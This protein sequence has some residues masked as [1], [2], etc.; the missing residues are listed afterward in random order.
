[1]QSKPSQMTAMDVISIVQLLNQNG[2]HV[3]I[4]GGWG[5]DAFWTKTTIATSGCCA[6]SLESMVQRS[7]RNS[8]H[9]Q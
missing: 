9:E 3:T 7:I 6:S 2:I 1:M 5:V 8:Q 4:D